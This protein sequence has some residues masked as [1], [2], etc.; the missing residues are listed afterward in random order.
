MTK[1]L[2]ETIRVMGFAVAVSSPNDVLEAKNAFG[3]ASWDKQTIEVGDNET[4]ERQQQS[5]LH[6][7]LHTASSSVLALD[8]QL[9]ERQVKAVAGVLHQIFRDNP[10]VLEFLR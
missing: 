8:E 6:E 3:A 9:N 7:L 2:P 1:K 4:L 10:A 5:L